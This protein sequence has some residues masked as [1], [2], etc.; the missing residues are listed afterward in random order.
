MEEVPYNND[1]GLFK[2]SL[3]AEQEVNTGYLLYLKMQNK[4]STKMVSVSHFLLEREETALLSNRE[5]QNKTQINPI[6]HIAKLALYNP[7]KFRVLIKKLI[8]NVNNKLL[9]G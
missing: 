5:I 8:L 2:K 1:I 6:K 4:T 3:W 9:I 7:T